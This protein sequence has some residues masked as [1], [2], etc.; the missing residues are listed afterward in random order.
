M[1]GSPVPGALVVAAGAAG[2][3][4]AAAA[5]V[6]ATSPTLVAATSSTLVAAARAAGRVA[7]ARALRLWGLAAVALD[8]GRE[9]VVAAAGA[10]PTLDQSRRQPR[11]ARQ[12]RGRMMS[13]KARD[14]VGR[15][16]RKEKSSA[17]L[18]R[19][20]RG[21]F[22]A[23]VINFSVGAKIKSEPRK[24]FVL[25]EILGRQA[26]KKRIGRAN[27]QQLCRETLGDVGILDSCGVIGVARGGGGWHVG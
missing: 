7:A 8:A 18:A 2:A 15:G 9:A 21:I 22:F 14:R 27:E 3:A 17:S 10:V 16:G 11:E 6:A 24:I 19:A 4:T 5:L 20:W 12:G 23:C 26:Q 25:K 1:R 13:N